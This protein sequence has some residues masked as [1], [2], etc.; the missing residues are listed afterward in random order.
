[1]NGGPPRI[2][3]FDSAYNSIVSTDKALFN[4]QGIAVAPDGLVWV[5]EVGQN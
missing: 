1:M 3:V 2:G 5:A 4:L